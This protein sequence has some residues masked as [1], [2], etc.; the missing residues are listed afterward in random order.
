MTG[1]DQALNHSCV[2]GEIWG[3]MRLIK[4]AVYMGLKTKIQVHL[5]SLPFSIIVVPSLS[6]QPLS[7]A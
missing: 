4:F 3:W 6:A 7:E 5:A 1:G 2:G